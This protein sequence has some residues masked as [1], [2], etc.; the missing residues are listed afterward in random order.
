MFVRRFE[1]YVL[2]QLDLRFALIALL[3]ALGRPP[4]VP[5]DLL[6][7]RFLLVTY[8]LLSCLASCQFAR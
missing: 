4:L 2:G 3:A 6:Q 7:V 8:W 1:I 5:I